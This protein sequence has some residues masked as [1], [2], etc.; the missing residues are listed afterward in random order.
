[1][2]LQ[3]KYGIMNQTQIVFKRKTDVDKKQQ[4]YVNQCHQLQNNQEKV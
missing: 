2:N 1:M 4:Q 3:N